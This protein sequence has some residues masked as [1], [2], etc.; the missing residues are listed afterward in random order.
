[1]EIASIQTS[2]INQADNYSSYRATIKLWARLTFICLIVCDPGGLK[3]CKQLR[4]N[5]GIASSESSEAKR[6]GSGRS[7]RNQRRYECATHESSLDRGD[8]IRLHVGFDYIAQCP[9][10]HAGIDKFMFDV[11]R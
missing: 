11:N 7:P 8:Q 10:R 4:R 5:L 9:L 6:S 3:T 2:T 1:V